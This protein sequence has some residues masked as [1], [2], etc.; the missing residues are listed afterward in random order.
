MR[1]NAA[2]VPLRIQGVSS[3]YVWE[4]VSEKILRLYINMP[5]TYLKRKSI[6]EKKTTYIGHH[7]CTGV[8]FWHILI[9][10]KPLS[11][12]RISKCV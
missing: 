8:F 12:L 10:K 4:G 9:P 5:L 2:G 1:D 3:E 6:K 7:H 11:G